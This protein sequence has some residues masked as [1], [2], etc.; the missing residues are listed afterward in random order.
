MS[1]H[2]INHF[3]LLYTKDGIKAA[4]EISEYPLQSYL[5][6]DLTEH[7]GDI[8]EIK[9]KI[10]GETDMSHRIEDEDIFDII[11]RNS[12]INK[13]KTLYKKFLYYVDNLDDEEISILKKQSHNLIKNN[14]IYTFF[15]SGLMT[16]IFFYYVIDCNL[17]TD[18]I[19]FS[20][21]LP[22]SFSGYGF[23]NRNVFDYLNLNLTPMRRFMSPFWTPI[24]MM[25]SN[26]FNLFSGFFVYGCNIDQTVR[27]M[28]SVEIVSSLTSHVSNILYSLKS[29]QDILKKD[30]EAME[31]NVLEKVEKSIY[32]I[33]RD[34]HNSL[35]DIASENENNR[36]L[37]KQEI[38]ASLKSYI[39]SNFENLKNR[40]ENI[41]E[42]LEF[43]MERKS[44]GSSSI[45]DAEN[46]AK[47]KMTNYKPEV[48][49]DKSWDE[50]L[51]RL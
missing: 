16:Y 46:W 11:V 40:I 18:K 7:D 14:D 22:T 12:T 20:I 10:V 17:I 9:M 32:K 49:K 3:T 33:E 50:H 44:N 8:T 37:Q 35:I 26:F 43:R 31:K 42:N 27:A 30:L 41:N 15:I 29:Q 48:N 6:L 47:P 38:H 19:P 24:I 25:V 28:Q 21:S 23:F 34:V 51:L 13:G 2:Q 39:D 36:E 5:A 1:K 4:D 45:F